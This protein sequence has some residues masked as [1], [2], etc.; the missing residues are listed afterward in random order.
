MDGARPTQADTPPRPFPRPQGRGTLP[1]ARPARGTAAPSLSP[2]PALR[3][4][5]QQRA[6]NSF[7]LLWWRGW[8]GRQ[9]FEQQLPVIIALE[10]ARTTW[11]N[12]AR[13]N[14]GMVDRYGC[15][16]FE[17]TCP[18]KPAPTKLDANIFLRRERA[19]L[20]E[21]LAHAGRMVS[22]AVGVGERWPVAHRSNG[23][24]VSRRNRSISQTG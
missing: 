17:R 4:A 13:R 19:P 22:L 12:H 6:P 20:V 21:Q 8:S 9:Q 10:A 24:L 15:G 1:L 2:R 16:L 18:R 7:L 5:L 3:S 23:A 14:D 11:T